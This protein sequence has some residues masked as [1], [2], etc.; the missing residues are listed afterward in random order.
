MVSA[1][2][3]APPTT[4]QNATLYQHAQEVMR[5]VKGARSRM[6]ALDNVDGVDLNSARGVVIIDQR[7]VSP[8]LTC[9][10]AG[11]KENRGNDFIFGQLVGK[12]MEVTLSENSEPGGWPRYEDQYVK[13]QD[14]PKE[15]AYTISTSDDTL[16]EGDIAVREDKT[17][18]CLEIK[19]EASMPFNLSGS[20]NKV[21]FGKV[22]F[23]PSG[24][25]SVKDAPFFRKGM[26]LKSQIDDMMVNLK[27]MDNGPRDLNPDPGIVV[28]A[29]FARESI[30]DERPIPLEAALHFDPIGGQVN[31]FSAG[32]GEHKGYSYH[33]DQGTE[34]YRRDLKHK[35]S[36]ALEIASDGS[37]VQWQY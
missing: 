28:V 6:E 26:E 8:G 14:S 30:P 23:P 24:P 19:Q 7:Q 32:Y 37:R 9:Q 27:G 13:Y 3:S 11:D 15:T 21:P 1:S 34:T 29:D 36:L 5:V 2:F 16:F 4:Q 31:E 20:P 22:S 12:D 33:A 18:G 10:L 17:N 25:Q 35:N